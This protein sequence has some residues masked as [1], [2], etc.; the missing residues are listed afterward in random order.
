MNEHIN[1]IKKIFY[2]R[3]DK[4]SKKVYIYKKKLPLYLLKNYAQK[5][6]YTFDSF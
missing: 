1:I 4:I 5:Y 3:L 2:K 6:P